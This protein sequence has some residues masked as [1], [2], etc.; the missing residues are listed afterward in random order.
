MRWLI[1][2]LVFGLLCIVFLWSLAVIDDAYITYRY[3]RNLA[4]GLGPVF[5][6]GERVEGCTT[7]FQMV[8]LAPF[9][10]IGANPGLISV[11]ISFLLLTGIAV[12]GHRKIA[13]AGDSTPNAAWAR[14]FPVLILTNPAMVHWALSGME[15]IWFTAALFGAVAITEKE[16]LRGRAPVVSAALVLLAALTRP[17]GVVAAA[18]LAFS[19]AI[20]EKEDRWKKLAVFCGVFAAGFG[21]YFIWRYSYY[22]YFFPNTYYAKVG[23]V[24]PALLKRGALYVTFGL[25]GQIIPPLVI[26]LQMVA[27]QKRWRLSRWEKTY[28]LVIGGQCFAA[29]RSGG[30]FLPYARFLAPVFPLFLLLGWSLSVRLFGAARPGRDGDGTVLGPRAKKWLLG[31]RVVFLALAVNVLFML[32]SFNELQMIVHAANARTYE[33]RGRMLKTIL[34]QNSVIAT[35]AIGAIGYV[36]D[37]RIIDLFGLTDETIAHTPVETGPGLAGHEKSNPRYVLKKRPDVI[38]LCVKFGPEP[39]D[40]CD[41]SGALVDLPSYKTLME[42]KEFRMVYKYASH[43]VEDGYLSTFVRRSRIGRPGYAGWFVPKSV[44]KPG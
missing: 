19:W 36:S 26:L 28:W 2:G 25:F 13:L 41:M 18:A 31:R 43:K 37:L 11:A 23:E 12:L 32:P 8:F 38:F 35:D 16:V 40:R 10:A 22:G 17:E 15:T 6:A 21:A 33:W 34:P 20:F 4:G 1:I 27:F 7:F 42:E 14:F 44:E 29:W 5:N 3:A 30:D 9:I 24:G 39:L